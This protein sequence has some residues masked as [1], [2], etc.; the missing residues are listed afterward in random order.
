[1]TD[2]REINAFFFSDEME[3]ASEIIQDAANKY[4]IDP[5]DLYVCWGNPDNDCTK[6]VLI[7]DTNYSNIKTE[8]NGT[9]NPIPDTDKS[10]E[11]R[12]SIAMNSLI[13]LETRNLKLFKPLVVHD[14]E[15]LIPE[16]DIMID[17]MTNMK[18]QLIT[19]KK[20]A[21]LDAAM[22]S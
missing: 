1:M 17:L 13:L 9:V 12:V 21:I 14:N 8:E 22:T 16:L 18:N 5:K 6:R 20:I 2:N 19:N 3:K 7:Y 4:L 11:E 10:I 15:W